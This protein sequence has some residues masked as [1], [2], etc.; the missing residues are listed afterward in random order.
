MI[1][2]CATT[3]ALLFGTGVLVSACSDDS[4]NSSTGTSAGTSTGTGG[5][6]T[7]SGTGGAGGTGGGAPVPID[8]S[9]PSGA[10]APLKLTQI[11]GGL[12]RP[13]LAK[14]APGDP[15]RL[16]IVSQNGRIFLIKNGVLQ[17]APFLDIDDLVPNV[18]GANERGLLGLAFHPDY[19]QN[20]R[21]FVHFT[22]TDNGDAR[23]VEF[24][25]GADAD[26]ADPT[27]VATVLTQADDESNH[28]GGS[29]EFSP[30][31]GLLYIGLGDGGGGGD[32]HGP[33]GNGQNLQTLF[34]KILR[35]DVT[36][37]PYTIP[38][39]NLPGGLPEIWDY[40]LRNPYRFSFDACGG[41]LYIGDVGQ[42]AWE[43]IDVEPAGQGNKNY[44]WRVMEGTHCYNPAQDC[45]PTGK[46]LP[47][48]E[49]SHNNPTEGCSVTGGYVYRGTAIPWLRG[50]YFYGDYC[51][52][53]IWTL[54][55]EGGVA[56]AP[57]N[58][59]Q[60]LGS[61]GF[62]VVGFGQDHAGEVYVTTLNGNVYRIDAE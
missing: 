59:T 48:A 47:V 13:L 3:G 33:D 36:S 25:R 53:N 15:S 46:T 2:V 4:S 1:L 42:G 32:Q 43:E 37:I 49:Y 51:T 60:D 34:G 35:I 24:K 22:D 17:Q 50:S 45:D 21:F 40:G 12:N 7:S 8:C 39:G 6:T 29:I 16:F 27:P 28:N 18:S 56:S 26:A 44:G 57:V 58:R 38:P 62:P 31:D 61:A 54:R 9:P 41:D 11:A 55:Y 19:P 14:S 5:S 30:I 10:E 20:G 23:I 52:G